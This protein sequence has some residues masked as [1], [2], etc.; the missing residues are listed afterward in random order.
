MN[1]QTAPSK[2]AKGFRIGKNKPG[3][4]SQSIYLGKAEKIKKTLIH[5]AKL[6]TTR[7][8]AAKAGYSTT[9]QPE[10]TANAYQQNLSAMEKSTSI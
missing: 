10:P 1:K 7:K 8:G 3:T 2:R 9:G 4:S 5:K 6:K